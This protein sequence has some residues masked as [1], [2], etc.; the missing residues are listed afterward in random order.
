M[1]MPEP[2]ASGPGII[3]DSDVGT[4]V[5]KRSWGTEIQLLPPPDS[6][7]AWV[8]ESDLLPTCCVTSSKLLSLSGSYLMRRLLEQ[9]REHQTVLSGEWPS[10]PGAEL[11]LGSCFHLCCCPWTPQGR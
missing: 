1:S 10:C 6:Q 2:R 9:L 8:L 4:L 11:S 5:C 3:L 7:E